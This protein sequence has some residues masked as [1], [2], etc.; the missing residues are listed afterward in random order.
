MKVDLFDFQKDALDDLREKLGAARERA[1]IES[2]Q[3]VSFSAPTG[4]G[5]TI[6]MAALFE[7]IFFGEADF[8][9]QPDAV[10]LWISDMPE[11]NEQT[12]LKIESKSDR[13]RTR[14]L[15]TIDSTFDAETLAGGHIYFVNTQKLGTDKLL[16]R[17]GDTRHYTIWETFTNTAKTMTDR[18]YV[19]IDE[20][21]RGMRT[22]SEAQRA[23]SILQRFIL[24]DNEVGLCRMPIL[25]GISATPE[26]FENLLRDSTSH[27]TYRCK[28]PAEEVRKSGLLKDR[29]LI[30][31]PDITS[32]ADMT[33][34]D[35]ATKC[36]RQ[37]ET[38]WRKYCQ[39]ETGCKV[40]PI[41]VI[42]VEDGYD[43]VLTRTDLE[44]VLSTIEGTLGESLRNDEVAHAFNDVGD[45]T[46][47]GRRVRKIEPSR[48][49]EDHSVRIVL[50]KLN[51]STGWD[52]PRAEVLVSFRSAQ[53]HTY[54]A[55][56]VGRMVRTPLARRVESDAALNDVYL[57]LPRYNRDAI[58]NVINDLQNNEEVPPSEV[59]VSREL[60]V[61]HR[62][63]GTDEIFDAITDHL[64]TYRV[65]AVRKQ[66]ALKR[67]MGISRGLTHD[68][69]D[70]HAL[71]ETTEMVVGWMKQEI[72]RL[73]QS[74]TF[75]DKAEQLIGI[76]LKSIAVEHGTDSITDETIYRIRAVS[77]DIDRLF[78]Q[79]GRALGS[80]LHMAYCKAHPD[81]PVED[82][83]MEVIV[84][85]QDHESMRNLEAQAEDK[86]NEL[87]LNHKHHINRLGEQRRGYYDKLCLAAPDPKPIPWRLPKTITFK[88]SSE[89][90]IYD[91][92][93]YVEEDGKFR[94]DL[95][96]WEAEVLEEELQDE[97][98]VAWLR[99][100]DR[101]PWSLEIPYQDATRTDRP[102]FP[103]ML[104]VRK[105]EDGYLFDILEPHD[106]SRDDNY[107][108]AIGLAKF[109]ERH[110]DK[111]DRVQLIRK[112]NTTG[113]PRYLRLDMGNRS[114]RR[115]VLT[116]ANN[117]QLNHLFNEKAVSG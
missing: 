52:C 103:D 101:K 11:L 46:I 84:L 104:I 22:T 100:I 105:G 73:H 68:D 5:K 39:K 36:W 56:L 31:H 15:A 32:Q 9:A 115:E 14:Q 60:V 66:S 29:I 41:L 92:H 2:P 23:Q 70:E 74:G 91:K 95:G 55:Q 72:E 90:R 88:R 109:S 38:H 21:H 49:E 27:T 86:F 71:K 87:Y 45:L 85:S 51:L 6:I 63:P 47:L 107:L 59:G 98:V 10:V 25:I 76:K 97:N 69:I 94:A 28:I 75:D 42:Q 96:P 64:L 12:R 116:I 1:S 37:V 48:I 99:N 3:V 13:I 43:N 114:V 93:L 111:F 30:H 89:A 58:D 106:P 113:G 61:L 34:L 4:S 54:I 108:K 77:A 112:M 24:G 26:R 81:R 82:V 67:L 18:F 50:F 33:I 53:D 83:K 8:D 62:R 35:E 40:N 57:F 16:T 44:N 110:G 102:M 117:Q 80:G 65:D 17:K 79:A 7:N 19:V 78:E 20:A